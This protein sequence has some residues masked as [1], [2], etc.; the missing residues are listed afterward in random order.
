M[1][2]YKTVTVG[3]ITGELD[4]VRVTSF[5]K[6]TISMGFTIAR[7]LPVT[8]ALFAALLALFA[9]PAN[10]VSKHRT[11]IKLTSPS[12]YIKVTWSPKTTFNAQVHGRERKAR[13]VHL[14]QKKNSKWVDVAKVKSDSAG[15][16]TKTLKHTKEGKYTY[17]WR[18]SPTKKSTGA[19]SKVITVNVFQFNP[20]GPPRTIPKPPSPPVLMTPPAPQPKVKVLSASGNKAF[21]KRTSKAG[22]NKVVAYL[23]SNSNAIASTRV[24]TAPYS[25]FT[26]IG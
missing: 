12:K 19:Y 10:A 21:G 1:A 3:C 22:S 11:V 6:G 4:I 18:V 16:V 15:R 9:A 2:R 8:F 20:G 17:R 7:R 26:F 23:G 5:N 24:A 13:I 14:Q 25:G